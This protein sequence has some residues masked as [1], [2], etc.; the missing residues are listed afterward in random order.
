M[1]DQKLPLT[2]RPS[3]ALKYQT[4]QMERK[5]ET[6]MDVTEKITIGHL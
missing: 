1:E 4:I 3:H 6:N 5:V 2:P